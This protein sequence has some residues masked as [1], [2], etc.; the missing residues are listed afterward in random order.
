MM[1]SSPILIRFGFVMRS[2]FASSSASSVM[3]NCAA[4]RDS[5]SPALIDVDLRRRRRGPAVGDGVAEPRRTGSRSTRRRPAAAADAEQGRQEEQDERGE[6][7]AAERTADRRDGGDPRQ[8]GPRL[9]RRV[10]LVR[11]GAPRRPIVVA[12]LGSGPLAVAVPRRADGR[13][14]RRSRRRPDLGK[15]LGR[16]VRA[17]G[18]TTRPASSGS[19]GDA[20]LSSGGDGVGSTTLAPTPRCARTARQAVRGA[21]G[22]A[23]CSLGRRVEDLVPSVGAAWPRRTFASRRPR[24][25]PPRPRWRRR[26]VAR[27]IP[28]GASSI[29]GSGPAWLHE[30]LGVVVSGP[31]TRHA[32][33]PPRPRDGDRRPLGRRSAARDACAASRRAQSW[34]VGQTGNARERQYASWWARARGAG[35]LGV[36]AVAVVRSIGALVA[37]VLERDER[38]GRGTVGAG[39]PSLRHRCG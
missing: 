1:I 28:P 2:L 16:L 13:A 18:A 12:S 10:R 8:P 37:I 32:D 36:A 7:H 27:R 19:A 35:G 6:R 38:T 24:P 34:K 5:V 20:G 9:D 23:P 15:R 30:S 17:R 29:G 14:P 22:Q 11:A 39:Q 4:I 21:A 31:T 33:A 26:P 3:L 25:R